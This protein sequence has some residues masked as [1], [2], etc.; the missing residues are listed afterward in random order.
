MGARPHGARCALKR[1]VQSELGGGSR[2]L[3]SERRAILSAV[4]AATQI[5]LFGSGELACNETF[6]GLE[7]TDLGD[8]A[9]VDHVPAWLSGEQGL[10]EL[11][12]DRLAWRSE[13]RTMYEREVDVPRLLASIGD[14]HVHP[15]IERMR[16]VL[17]ARYG[18]EFARTS[19]A[20]YRDGRDSVAFHGDFPA[21]RMTI[22]TAV[23]TISLGAPRTF[24][25]RRKGGG[26]SRTWSLGGGDLFVM[27]GSCQRTHEHAIPKAQRASA[28]IALMY[29][30]VWTE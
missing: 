20:L 24:R 13:S 1:C 8:G 12:R 4:S 14:A 27:G 29:R 3:P 7:R 25:V 5:P 15:V 28:R 19:A 30:P 6:A 9:W 2:Q 16:T 21:R 26:P 18:E 23:A 10:F 11:L 22:D 17:G